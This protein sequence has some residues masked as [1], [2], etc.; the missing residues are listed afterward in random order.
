MTAITPTGPIRYS[1]IKILLVLLFLTGQ[2]LGIFHLIEHTAEGDN[3]HCDICAMAA[4]MG[5]TVLP[6]PAILILPQPQ[7]DSSLQVIACAFTA[8]ICAAYT[9]RAPPLV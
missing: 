9:S 2:I 4:H 6:T 8:L 1:S 7:V 3:D 5:D